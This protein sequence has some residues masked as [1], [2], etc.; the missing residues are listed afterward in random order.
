MSTVPGPPMRPRRAVLLT[1]PSQTSAFLQTRLS[2]FL[3]THP[4][5]LSVSPL[6]AT[7]PKTASRKP[8]VCHTCD[9]PRGPFFPFRNSPSFFCIGRRPVRRF[10]ALGFAVSCGL[11]AVN[12]HSPCHHPFVPLHRQSHSATMAKY[13]ETSPPLPV[14]KKSERTRFRV[15]AKRT[16]G[17]AT[18]RRRTRK[19]LQVVPE[20]IVL[21]MDRRAGWPKLASDR[22]LINPASGK[23][24]GKRWVGKAGSVR[25]G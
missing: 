14:S 24:A 5:N 11:S 20:S 25:L 9:T 22:M 10:F 23:D 12:S 2:P 15:S 13:W 21:K 7:L 6:L 18:A 17:P 3:A 16:T 4:K 19:R 8:F 1:P